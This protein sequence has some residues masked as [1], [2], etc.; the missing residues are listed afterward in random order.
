MSAGILILRSLKFVISYFVV[1]RGPCCPRAF[2]CFCLLISRL[3]VSSLSPVALT[4]TGPQKAYSCTLIDFLFF[5]FFF[6]GR[7]NTALYDNMH[8]VSNQIRAN[9]VLVDSHNLT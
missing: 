1:Q 6:W 9:S 3:S 4:Q 7:A 2:L 8:D 5:C